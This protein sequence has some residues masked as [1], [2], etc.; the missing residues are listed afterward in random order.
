MHA[1]KCNPN[2]WI[3]CHHQPLPALPDL[4]PRSTYTSWSPTTAN[5]S[6]R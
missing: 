1:E 2:Y 4:R 3:Q 6:N 5:K